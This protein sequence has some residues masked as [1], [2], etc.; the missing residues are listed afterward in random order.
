M[1]AEASKT[2]ANG[3][4][5]A[6]MDAGFDAL[7]KGKMSGT[8]SPTLILLIAHLAEDGGEPTSHFRTCLDIN[9][10]QNLTPQ[11]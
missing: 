5:S 4:S 3:D 8:A 2:S 9:K 6:R 1:P 10:A 11:T 7:E